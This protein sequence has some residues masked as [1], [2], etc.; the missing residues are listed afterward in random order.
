MTGEL[1]LSTWKGA[2]VQQRLWKPTGSLLSSQE[3]LSVRPG[4]GKVHAG[5]KW[6]RNCLLS[7]R[8]LTEDRKSC[9]SDVD[10]REGEKACSLERALGKAQEGISLPKHD[11]RE[12]E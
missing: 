4:K 8:T 5:A 11:H 6:V 10:S 7:I 9:C 2:K 3:Q 12:E 1:L